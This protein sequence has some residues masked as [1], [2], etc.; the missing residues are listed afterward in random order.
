[1]FGY[2][3][4]DELTEQGRMVQYFERQRFKSATGIT[5]ALI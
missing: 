4:S 1:V 2:P 5:I 3:L